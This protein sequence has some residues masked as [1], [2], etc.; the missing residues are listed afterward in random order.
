MLPRAEVERA[1]GGGGGGR[2]GGGRGG[3]GGGSNPAG[4]L[5]LFVERELVPALTASGIRLPV[6]C[7]GDGLPP[8]IYA[9]DDEFREAGGDWDARFDPVRAK[10]AIAFR[11]KP[12]LVLLLLPTAKSCELLFTAMTDISSEP[13]PLR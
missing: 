11:C 2:G 10:A 3:G 7:R 9:D 6:P 5:R 8:I 13:V 12:T 1:A 4:S